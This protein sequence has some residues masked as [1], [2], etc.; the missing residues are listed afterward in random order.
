MQADLTVV[1][2]IAA[3]DITYADL[4]VT[5]L[6]KAHRKCAKEIILIVDDTKAQFSDF[7]DH[8]K[9][10]HEPNFSQKIQKIKAIAQQLKQDGLVDKVINTSDFSARN[11]SK[12]YSKNLVKATHDFRGA[13]ITAYL[14][15]FEICTTQ[16]LVRYDGDMLL[17]QPNT[18]W[19]LKGIELLKKYPDCIAVSPQPSP[20]NQNQKNDLNFDPTYWFSTRC[21]LFDQFKLINTIPFIQVKYGIEL[22]LRKWLNKTYPPAFETILVQR[23]KKLNF[24]NYYLINYDCWLLHPEN[25]NE[26][27]INLLPEILSAIKKGNYPIE[28]ANQETLALDIWQKYF[29]LNAS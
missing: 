12:K 29:K 26:L 22:L 20:P 14:V 21:T 18:D 23:L 2:N 3:G 24:K 25:K 9:R 8:Q 10:Y 5:S 6:A 19:A 1:I 27:F 15:G 28:Q 13:P 16:Y 7:Y 11:L 4:T 17:Y